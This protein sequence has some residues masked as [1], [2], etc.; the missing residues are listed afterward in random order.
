MTRK[1]FAYW[2]FGLVAFYLVSGV[3]GGLLEV[4]ENSEDLNNFVWIGAIFSVSVVL[5]TIAVSYPFFQRIV[6]RARDAGMG[7]AI[8]YCSIIP[9]VFF[10]TGIFLLL[11]GRPKEPVE[12]INQV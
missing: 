1:G 6:R 2:V 9:G 8:A 10:F 5:I 4:Q 3:I 11:K 7:K 12:K